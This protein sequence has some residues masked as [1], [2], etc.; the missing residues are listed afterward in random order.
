MWNDLYKEEPPTCVEITC[1]R[2]SFENTLFIWKMIWFYNCGI[3]E[4]TADG[5]VKEQLEGASSEG[6]VGGVWRE[7]GVM[8]KASS[9]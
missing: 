9:L 3:R 6:E 8:S 5:S 2:H 1:M 4:V 7:K